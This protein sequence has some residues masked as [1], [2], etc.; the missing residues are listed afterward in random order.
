MLQYCD[1]ISSER[2]TLPLCSLSYTLCN[3]RNHFPWRFSCVATDAHE[4][5]QQLSAAA[6]PRVSSSSIKDAPVNFVFTGQG[7]QWAGM[8]RE[9]LLIKSL[10]GFSKSIQRS[11]ELLQSLGASWDLVEEI[12]RDEA[13]SRLDS[14]ELA[15]PATTAIQLALVDMFADLGIQPTAVIGHS[16]G[17]IAASYAAGYISQPTALR[18]AY[19]RGFTPTI[20]RKNISSEGA[21]LAVGLGEDSIA[22]YFAQVTQGTVTIACVNSPQSVTVSGDANAIDELA[23]ILRAEDVFFRKLRVNVA[24]HSHHMQAA[25]E[26]YGELI[27]PIETK[28]QQEP[29]DFYST[30]SGKIKNTSF[31]AQYWVENLVSKVRFQEGIQ[32]LCQAQKA[33]KQIFIEIGPHGTLAGPT[34]QII[35]A[36]SDITQ[37]DYVSPLRRGMNAVRSLLEAIGRLFECGKQIDLSILSDLDPSMRNA[38]V[39]CGLPGYNWDHGTKHWYESRVSRNHRL[40]KHPYHDL[41][42]IQSTESTSIEPRWRHMIGLAS[43]PWLADHVVDG[44]VVFPGSGYVCMAI[45]GILQLCREFHPH[46]RVSHVELEDV[47]FMKA[48][49]VPDSPQRLETQLSFT[50]VRSKKQKLESMSYHFL[51]AAFSHGQSWDE[52]CRGKVRVRFAGEK[53]DEQKVEAW[54]AKSETSEILVEDQIYEQLSLQ[55]NLYGPAFKGVSKILMDD[56]RSLATMVVPNV[57]KIMPAEHSQPHAIHPAT[58]D[59]VM[60]A[61][62]PLIT[63]KLAAGSVMPIRIDK[64]I[65]STDL[66][67]VPGTSLSTRATIS[68]THDR[69]GIMNIEVLSEECNVPTLTLSGVELRVLAPLTLPVDQGGIVDLSWNM[70]WRPDVDFADPKR[71]FVHEEKENGRK[72]RALNREAASYVEKYL[73]QFSRNPHKIVS[74]HEALHEWMLEHG[75]GT[76]ETGLFSPQ[77]N[78]TISHTSQANGIIY[79]HD[80]MSPRTNGTTYHASYANGSNS[81]IP[82]T[83]G[84]AYEDINIHGSITDEAHETDMAQDTDMEL[85]ARTGKALSQIVTGTQNALDLVMEEDLLFKVY[86]SDLS[87]PSFDLLAQYTKELSFK[88]SRLRIIEIGAGT[89]GATKPILEAMKDADSVPAIY[90]FTDVSTGF[91]DRAKILL[92]DHVIEY[93]RLDIEKDPGQQGF[94]L[95]S[96]DVVLAF[97]CIHATS[98][99][100]TTLRHVK[101]LLNPDG[102]LVLIELVHPQPFHH[103]TFGTLSG[104]WK[105][106]GDRRSGGPFMTTK[107]W[108]EEFEDASLEMEMELKDSELTHLNSVMIARHQRETPPDYFGEVCLVPIGPQEQQGSVPKISTAL[109]KK[110]LQVTIANF[111]DCFDTKLVT[112]ILD[113]GHNPLLSN[114]TPQD[115]EKLCQALRR[116]SR[117]LWISCSNNPSSSTNPKKHLVTGLA[118]SAHAENSDLRFVTID[119]QQSTN[120]ENEILFDAIAECAYNSFFTSSEFVERELVFRGDTM[121]IPRLLPSTALNKWVRKQEKSPE[122]GHC[123]FADNSLVL[124]QDYVSDPSTLA[125]MENEPGTMIGENEVQLQVKAM[126]ITPASL[127][128]RYVEYSGTVTSV[129]TKVFGFSVG[130]RVMALGRSPGASRPRVLANLTRHIPDNMAYT[131]AAGLPLASMAASF[132]LFNLVAPHKPKRILLQGISCMLGQALFLLSQRQSIDI[133]VVASN[134]FEVHLLSERFELLKDRI[135]DLHS[136]HDK[137]PNSSTHESKFDTIISCESTGVTSQITTLLNPFGFLLLINNGREQASSTN[138]FQLPPNVTTRTYDVEA[139]LDATPEE[140]PIVLGRS[141]ELVVTAPLPYSK[142][143]PTIEPISGLQDVFTR[144]E[145]KGT[146]EK[147]VFE[148]SDDSI[149]P[150]VRTKESDY[151]LPSQATYIIAGGLGDLGK[152][153]VKHLARH[154]ARQIITLSRRSPLPEE[155]SHVESMVRG[156]SEYC[157]VIHLK[158]DISREEEVEAAAAEIATMDLPPVKGIVQS[159][160]VLRV[161]YLFTTSTYTFS[162]VVTWISLHVYN[163]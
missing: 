130:D 56:E 50:P 73:E 163:H 34:K 160:M 133:W 92:S 79:Q 158:C 46:R 44:S 84:F 114:I 128:S 150:M 47:E 90:H 52:H 60:H 99:M 12:L 33:S 49:L 25:A 88:K 113:D 16:S 111:E 132:A 35:E 102:R 147:I 116:E 156:L 93:R 101:S 48:L 51:V 122:I 23:S 70:L 32:E 19:Y 97:N 129:G 29:I 62:L 117:I 144:F 95:G 137:K 64:L 106:V 11:S 159:A 13:E 135:I 112:I 1:F 119:V 37:I 94:E 100:N 9:L 17:E 21:M 66:S 131:T 26:E 74:E 103:L 54:P 145:V 31:D 87:N 78:G 30:V 28:D 2:T 161:S 53:Q 20:V 139:W 109:V 98:N 141:I 157:Q 142:F 43:L 149:V 86:Q 151:K 69:T 108:E 153:V 75:S 162:S 22:V 41:V 38:E 59:I 40:R 77:T 55:G 83:N 121:R 138:Q 7:S 127:G 143:L 68:S 136:L 110:G 61:S 140:L 72:I 36:V 120:G 18:V 10:P 5:S 118:R 155:W 154:G 126:V 63:K 89:G 27:G 57:A 45:E 4:L 76:E 8:G 152:S 104:Y 81:Q 85:I 42:G 3:R 148:V 124:P 14:A 115:F 146:D 6:K 58:L 107:R 82:K 96:Y 134:P 80:S 65:L 125:F 24:Y 67:N 71:F 91:F 123:N 39:L 105:G 15:Q